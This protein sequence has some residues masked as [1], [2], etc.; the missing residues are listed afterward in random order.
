MQSLV[1]TVFAGVG[2]QYPYLLTYLLG[3]CCVHRGMGDI[4]TLCPSSWFLWNA[5]LQLSE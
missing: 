2:Y 4:L 5:R 3:E 1:T